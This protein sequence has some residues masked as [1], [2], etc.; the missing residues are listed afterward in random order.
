MGTFT[1]NKVTVHCVYKFV[2][3]DK[4]F[5]IPPLAEKVCLDGAT[6]INNQNVV[7]TKNT[8]I[9]FFGFKPSI[10]AFN[11]NI[12]FCKTFVNLVR[13]YKLKPCD[14]VHIAS[15]K[16]PFYY[17]EKF[18]KERVCKTLLPGLQKHLTVYTVEYLLNQ[19]C[20]DQNQVENCDS[21]TF[22]TKLMDFKIYGL[23]HFKIGIH[24][25]KRDSI[26][27]HY[28]I[29]LGKKFQLLTGFLEL[30]STLGG[31][32]M[33]QNDQY[34]MACIVL[35]G[36]ISNFSK[37]IEKILN[38]FVLIRKYRI[39]I[40]YYNDF[41]PV[42]YLVVN[43]RD[44]FVLETSDFVRYSPTNQTNFWKS[45]NKNMDNF[46]IILHIL[47]RSA[48]KT[49]GSKLKFTLHCIVL[50]HDN[51]E[52]VLQFTSPLAENYLQFNDNDI[53]KLHTKN[54]CLRHD[55]QSR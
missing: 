33:L 25:L 13:K 41:I 55:I 50:N 3:N 26:Y 43:I 4:S 39:I 38:K 18:L 22:K 20:K 31:F 1:L 27:W 28:G 15:I 17:S 37:G 10:R 42:Q 30:E 11:H 40:E 8:N 14:I 21:S 49:I 32:L 45:G 5:A 47:H 53:F 16:Y 51:L 24:F 35:K 54:R 2:N 52:C 23:E 46:N 48:V 7:L 44:I 36:N 6:K 9:T 12:K 34:K 19:L 29:E